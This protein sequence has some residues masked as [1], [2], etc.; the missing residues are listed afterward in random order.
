MNWKN[1]YSTIKVGDKVRIIGNM[2]DNGRCYEH[3]IGSIVTIKAVLKKG[4]HTACKSKQ[5]YIIEP[6]PGYWVIYAEMIEK[7]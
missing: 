3:K 6:N 2:T 7:V 5:A 4:E 1:R